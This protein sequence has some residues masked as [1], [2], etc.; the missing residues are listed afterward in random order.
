MQRHLVNVVVPP[1]KSASLHDENMGHTGR[2]RRAARDPQLVEWLAKVLAEQVNGS[3]DWPEFDRDQLARFLGKCGVDVQAAVERNADALLS[4]PQELVDAE[5]AVPK[6][7]GTTF[8]ASSAEHVCY[9]L[10]KRHNVASRA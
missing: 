1:P 8:I 4:M 9:Q 10:R 3:R 5:K 7:Q 6:L 2:D